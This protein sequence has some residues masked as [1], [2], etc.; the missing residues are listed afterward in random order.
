MTEVY[1]D[2]TLVPRCVKLIE[3]RSFG[4]DILD[5]VEAL[6][7][8]FDHLHELGK[9]Y[10]A[11]DRQRDAIM[12]DQRKAEPGR[13][14]FEIPDELDREMD[15]C[16]KDAIVFVSFVYYELST[17]VSL[18]KHDGSSIGVHLAYLVG[19]RNKILVHPRRDGRIKNSQSGL[20]FGPIIL[21]AHLVGGQTWIPLVRDW[22]V[23]EL[24]AKGI[25]FD[26][27]TGKDSNEALIRSSCWASKF[28]P[29][30][31]LQ[32]KAYIIPEPD[33]MA[34]A[35]EM[36]NLLLAEFLPVFEEVCAAGLHSAV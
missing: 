35:Y 17:L 10:L 1:E 24:T 29:E 9:R 23:R 8:A 19:V 22:Y 33:L 18:F 11:A 34:S 36:A 27:E 7:T 4:F 16:H 6:A 20:T 12:A 30:Q 28:T 25:Q 15:R 32:L 5:R 26:D 13:V 14:S 31:V 3:D 2:A 21:H